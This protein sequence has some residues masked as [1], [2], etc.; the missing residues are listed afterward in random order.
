ME[1]VEE[2]TK[3]IANATESEEKMAQIAL[4]RLC[5]AL[6]AVLNHGL[7]PSLET[8]FG[9][10]SNSVW[11]VVEASSQQGWYCGYIAHAVHYEQTI[12]I[13]PCLCFLY[14]TD[15]ESSSRIGFTPQ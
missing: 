15:D 14:R 9:D 1:A 4:N 5:P 3:C 10:I 7:R 8:A 2:A 11:Q 13:S 12:T 6:Y